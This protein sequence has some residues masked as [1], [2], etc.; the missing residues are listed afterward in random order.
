MAY[1]DSGKMIRKAHLGTDEIAEFRQRICRYYERHGRVLPWRRADDPYE[2]L[3]SEVML[4]QTQVERVIQKY[5]LFLKEFPDFPSLAHCNLRDLLGVWQ[6]LGYNRRALALQRTSRIVM[7]SFDGC[8]PDS[9]EQLVTLPGIG[10]ATAGALMAFA[11]EQPVVFIE[12]NIRRVFIHSFFAGRNAVKDSEIL[13][14]VEETLDRDRVRAWYYGLMD[15]GVMLRSKEPNPN[16]RSAHY[17]R[18]SPFEGSNRQIRGLILKALVNTRHMTP[19]EIV[20]SLETNPDR[21]RKVVRDLLEEGFLVRTGDRVSL[22][23]GRR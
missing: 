12:T 6:G 10:P 5:S 14:L 7:D 8:L 11:F 22:S 20:A 13:P 16:R 18:Q 9:N 1:G 17:Q 19:D 3:V 23:S 4:Q 21:V 2:I 15:Y